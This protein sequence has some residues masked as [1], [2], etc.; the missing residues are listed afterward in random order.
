MKILL[1]HPRTVCSERCNDIA[2]TPLA[3]CL[4]SGYVASMLI[5]EGHEVDNH[6][7]FSG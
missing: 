4:H 5:N 2:N 7:R 6:R 1:E 3:S